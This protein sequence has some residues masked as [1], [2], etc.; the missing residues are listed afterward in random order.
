MKII[1]LVGIVRLCKETRTVR[2]IWEA[3]TL[4]NK[5]AICAQIRYE[6]W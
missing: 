1:E 2:R 4:K 3:R 5:R 6:T